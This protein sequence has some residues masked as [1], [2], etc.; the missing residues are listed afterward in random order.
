MRTHL[1][2]GLVAVALAVG[3]SDS[4]PTQPTPNPGGT[5]DGPTARLTVTIDSLGSPEAV[6]GLSNVT[7]DASESSGTGLT[8][9][10]EF[11]DGTTASEAVARHVYAAAARSPRRS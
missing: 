6:T 5:S 10:V 7:I 11:G 9:R 4:S 1:R 8:Y 3:C 2:A